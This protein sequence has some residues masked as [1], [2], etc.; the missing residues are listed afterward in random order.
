MNRLDTLRRDVERLSLQLLD[1][2]NQRARVVQQIADE[3]RRHALPLRDSRRE[4]ELLDRLAAANPGPFDDATVRA[5][6]RDVFDASVA[7]MEGGARARLR[8]GAE[9]GPRLAVTARGH[10][11]GDGA[12]VWIAGPCSVES[13]EQIERA[14][15]GLAALGVGFLRGGAWKPRT[16]PYAFQGLGRPALELL[17]RAAR[18][19]GMA[20]VTE[21]TTPANVDAVAELADVIQIGAR[22]MY[23]YELLR[24]AGATGRAV[25]LKRAFSATLEEW[26]NAAEYVALSGSEAIVLCERGVRTF[27]RETRATLDVSAVPLALAASRLPVV[28][29][30]SHAAGRRDILGALAGA[31]F[32]VGAHGV[33][34]EV[35]PDPDVALS[36]AEQQI[37]IDDFA[38]LQRAVADTLALTAARL[39][40][41][42]DIA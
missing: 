9:A 28:V 5:L 14:A 33:M 3:K 39:A 35:H 6:F 4:Q 34:V 13:E 32:A 7:L 19:H 22:N 2:L 36:D 26:L 16:S 25:L 38:A 12:P 17:S 18:R 40:A 42:G 20:V 30:V 31:A 8:I 21:A 29:D 23:N 24:A 41:K 10:R 37:N 1:L 15:R 11:L 27:A